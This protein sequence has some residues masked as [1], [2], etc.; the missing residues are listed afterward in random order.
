MASA[1]EHEFVVVLAR[2][3]LQQSERFFAQWHTVPPPGLHA[4][5]WYRPC[6]TDEIDLALLAPRTSP[7]RAAVRIVNS[8]ARATMLSCSRGNVDAAGIIFGFWQP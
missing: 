4:L 5:G 6:R 8:S 2:Q 1:D 7:E 3:R